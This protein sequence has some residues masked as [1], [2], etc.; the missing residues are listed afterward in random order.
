MGHRDI[1][2]AELRARPDLRPVRLAP[3]ALG[4]GRP[5][6]ALVVSPAH[7][8]MLR[9]PAARALFNT[10]EVLVAAADLVNDRSV[11]R[12]HG[13]VGLRYIHVM[14][15]RHQ[16]VWANGVPAESFDPTTAA[17][18]ALPADQSA[19][20]RLACDG[21]PGGIAGF[22]GPARR[23]LGAGEA[24]ILRHENGWCH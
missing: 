19:L 23:C 3:G 17:L 14:F 2:E 6:A 8:L 16:I 21:L 7:R 22:G 15:A 13:P 11:V 20:L 18:S 4:V 5:D 9:G 12:A 24:A 1:S 10:P